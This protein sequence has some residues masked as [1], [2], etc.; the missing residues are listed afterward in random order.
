MAVQCEQP[1]GHALA[2]TTASSQQ[3]HHSA[4]HSAGRPVNADSSPT[5][6]LALV[7]VN[8]VIRA[9]RL[10]LLL[11]A[12]LLVMGAQGRLELRMRQ[13]HPRPRYLYRRWGGW[14]I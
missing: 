6:Q 9:L 12:L 11:V 14:C 13:P 8:A 5:L 10:G 2:V 3:E 7:R 4:C 1:R